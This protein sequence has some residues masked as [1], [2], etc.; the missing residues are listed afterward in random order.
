MIRCWVYRKVLQEHACDQHHEAW[1]FSIR[2]LSPH[3][4][5]SLIFEP[6]G[7]CNLK[8]ASKFRNGTPL[9]TSAYMSPQINLFHLMSTPIF[10]HSSH[11]AVISIFEQAK[12]TTE[13]NK[14]TRC[15]YFTIIALICFELMRSSSGDL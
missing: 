12:V 14:K 6:L 4:W 2:V 10:F 9:P 1:E 5:I 13:N 15:K 7:L 8:K 11:H 3:N